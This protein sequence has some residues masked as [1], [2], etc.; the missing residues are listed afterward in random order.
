MTHGDPGALGDRDLGT[1]INK[2]ADSLARWL[3]KRGIKVPRAKLRS[4]LCARLA[5]REAPKLVGDGAGP[6]TR[7]VASVVLRG[8]L[9]SA[10]EEPIQRSLL[11]GRR[12]GGKAASAKVRKTW[13]R[14]DAKWSR[15]AEKLN[16]ELSLQAKARKIAQDERESPRTVYEG[17]RRH[18]R[19]KRT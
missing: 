15:R 1:A 14:R 17:L 2:A 18:R 13:G 3:A 11:N 16:P 9:L 5:D 19:R 7:G 12:E 4:L 8:T 10:T 6:L